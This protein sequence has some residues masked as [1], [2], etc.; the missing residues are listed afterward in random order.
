MDVKAKGCFFIWRNGH[1][2]DLIQ[3]RLDRVFV[4]EAALWVPR[5]GSFVPPNIGSD[6]IIL[7]LSLIVKAFFGY[8]MF[9]R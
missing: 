7:V 4:N 2:E 5:S 8:R 3:E 1:D 9:M 6:H